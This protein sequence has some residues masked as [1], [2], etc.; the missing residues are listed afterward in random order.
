MQL[1]LLIKEISPLT[2]SINFIEFLSRCTKYFLK[3]TKV[4]LATCVKTFEV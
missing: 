4:Y 3:R 1:L 2:L